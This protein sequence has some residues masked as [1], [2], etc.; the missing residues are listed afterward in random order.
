M[1]HHVIDY[2]QNMFAQALFCGSMMAPV[3]R[4]YMLDERNLQLT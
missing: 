1:N 4:R 2:Y 3:W